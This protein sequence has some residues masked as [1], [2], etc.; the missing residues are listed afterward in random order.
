M[1]NDL[2]T[3]QCM[4]AFIGFGAYHPVPVLPAAALR[5][6]RTGLRALQG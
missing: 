4:A 3:N 5:P 1:G 6:P 2:K